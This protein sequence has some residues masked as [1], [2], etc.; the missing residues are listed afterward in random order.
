MPTVILEE[1]RKLHSVSDNLDLIAEQFPPVTD[2]LF[3]VAVSIRN[4]ATLLE[5]L[6]ATKLSP[7]PDLN[8]VTDS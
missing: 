8:P 2:A 7:P 6:V 4:T 1:A 3:S 5:V